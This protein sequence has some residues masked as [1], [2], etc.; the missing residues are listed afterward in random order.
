MIVLK[1]T[2]GTTW[3]NLMAAIVLLRL[4]DG[5]FNLEEVSKHSSQVPKREYSPEVFRLMP[6][7]AMEYVFLLP[8]SKLT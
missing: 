7:K 1:G 3:R 5:H 2:L 4:A 6:K 8:S